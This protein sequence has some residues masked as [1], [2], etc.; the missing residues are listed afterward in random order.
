MIDTHAHLYLPDFSE[1]LSNVVQQAQAVGI[2]EIWIPA[3]NTE[4][5]SEM[6]KLRPFSL[7]HFFAGL[8]PCDVKGNFREELAA[9]RSILDK[10]SYSGIG[11]IGLD[12]YWDKTF[13]AEQK[14]ALLCQLDWALERRQPALIHVRDAYDEIMPLIRPYYAKGLKGI[15]HSFAGTL[16]QAL[17]LTSHGFLLGINGVITY[18]NSQVAKFLSAVSLTAI[19][20]ETDAPYLTPVP[21]RG[22]RNESRHIPLIVAKLAEIY[23]LPVATIANQTT[24]NA[25]NLLT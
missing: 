20:T 3:I 9:I 4:S 13:L 14:E 7:F 12:L 24:L 19:V 5:L 6:E 11:E 18:K 8:H 23:H 21:F 16:E 2:D 17:E 25:R 10:G 1:D 15:F 22:K